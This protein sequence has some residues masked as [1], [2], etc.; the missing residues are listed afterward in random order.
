M[1]QKP[2]DIQ[3]VII[4]IKYDTPGLCESMTDYLPFGEECLD[5]YKML[6][7]KYSNV[8]TDPEFINF[9]KELTYQ[10]KAEGETHIFNKERFDYDAVFNNEVFKEW[11]ESSKSPNEAMTNKEVFEKMILRTEYKYLIRKHNKCELYVL[12]VLNKEYDNQNI[13]YIENIV[14][15]FK[16]DNEDLYLLLHDKDLYDDSKMH[17]PVSNSDK[18]GIKLEDTS[19]LKS[20]INDNK[21]FV[22]QHKNEKDGDAYY[23]DIILKLNDLSTK[24]IIEKL[25]EQ[26]RVVLFA[27]KISKCMRKSEMEEFMG[28]E[29]ENDKYDFSK[30]FID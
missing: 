15:V 19:K 21:V 8:F 12:P 6:F 5:L 4:T 13:E 25:E 7:L 10:S 14:K 18:L 30:P 24:E 2:F 28:S 16:K 9:L 1:V 26:A 27:K 3:K 29:I 22:F 17:H 11:I 23:K 20:L